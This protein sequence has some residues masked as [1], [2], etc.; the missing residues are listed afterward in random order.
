M[1]LTYYASGQEQLIPAFKKSILEFDY[2][3]TNEGAENYKPIKHNLSDVLTELRKKNPTQRVVLYLLNCR[4]INIPSYFG[5][6]IGYLPVSIKGNTFLMSNKCT[7]EN[8]PKLDKLEGETI[9]GEGDESLIMVYELSLAQKIEII[10][11]IYDD[12]EKKIKNFSIIFRSTKNYRRSE[13]KDTA[14]PSTIYFY[15][16]ND[17]IYDLTVW[18]AFRF[19][20]PKDLTV[21]DNNDGFQTILQRDFIDELEEVDSL[22]DLLNQLSSNIEMVLFFH[23]DPPNNC[24]G[25]KCEIGEFRKRV[26]SS[27]LGLTNIEEELNKSIV[28]LKSINVY[29]LK[30]VIPIGESLF[31]PN[32][33][34]ISNETNQIVNPIQ[35]TTMS[36]KGISK[37]I[38]LA[39]NSESNI[40]YKLGLKKIDFNRVNSVS[41]GNVNGPFTFPHQLSLRTIYIGFDMPITLDK[42]F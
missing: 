12:N 40:I 28:Q 16:D 24:K 2:W 34:F 13:S 10:K 30:N 17:K 8:V 9:G 11:D 35:E 22:D 37:G 25:Y 31:Y 7:I 23:P 5:D 33:F 19:N 29:E 1:E 14:E 39:Y 21:I 36:L 32:V 4:N 38:E 41:M 42:I 20:N 18:Y 26:V 3:Y 15:Y 6:C 27:N